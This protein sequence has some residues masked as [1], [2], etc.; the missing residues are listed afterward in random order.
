MV[1]LMVVCALASYTA[2]VYVAAYHHALTSNSDVHTSCGCAHI[3]SDVE[4][5]EDMIDN[6]L[7]QKRKQKTTHFFGMANGYILKLPSHPHQ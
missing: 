1:W 2:V 7:M 6:T 5:K 4:K 3:Q